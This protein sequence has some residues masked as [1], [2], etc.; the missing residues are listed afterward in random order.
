MGIQQERQTV[1]I[2]REEPRYTCEVVRA[3]MTKRYS[4][5]GYLQFLII[6]RLLSHDLQGHREL[7]RRSAKDLMRCMTMTVSVTALRLMV[8]PYK[9]EKMQIIC[10]CQK[11]LVPSELPYLSKAK[12]GILRSYSKKNPAN[13]K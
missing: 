7:F 10:I 8:T 4:Q 13:E 5:F 6:K 11:F 12:Q 2:E 3:E 9:Q 1:F